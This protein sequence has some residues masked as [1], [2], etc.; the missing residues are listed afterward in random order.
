MGELFRQFI[1]SPSRETFLA[2]RQALVDSDVY[3]PYSSECESAEQLIDSEQYDA[4]RKRL[5]EAMPNLLLSPRAHLLLAYVAEKLGDTDAMNAER[6]FAIRCVEGLVSSGDGTEAS[7]WQVLRTS[8]E[9]DVLN[10]RGR[11]MAQQA[12]VEN[13]GRRFDL[14]TCDDGSQLWFEV[15]EPFARMQRS[16]KGRK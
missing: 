16:L 3:S 15:T 7:P 12:L 9:Y 6:F 1:E 10:Y 11:R 4:A 14:L 2:V 13:G 8:D 5:G